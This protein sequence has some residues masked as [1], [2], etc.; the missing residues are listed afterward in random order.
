MNCESAFWILKLKACLSL[1]ERIG[2]SL[3]NSEVK[4]ILEI[5]TVDE[6]HAIYSGL[7]VGR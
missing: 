3:P 7:R 5:L 2:R 1:I 4:K 6:A